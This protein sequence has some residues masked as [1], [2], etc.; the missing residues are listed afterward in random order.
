VFFFFFFCGTPGFF[1][2]SLPGVRLSPFSGVVLFLF[3]PFWTIVFVDEPFPFFFVF[4]LLVGPVFVPPSFWERFG[5]F[6]L[7]LARGWWFRIGV[8]SVRK[9]FVRFSFH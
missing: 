9:E 2:L 8:M 3:L 5:N 6:F 1:P 7:V 4:W